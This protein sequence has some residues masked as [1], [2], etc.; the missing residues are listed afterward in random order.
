MTTRAFPTPAAF[1]GDR[2]VR[3]HLVGAGGTGSMLADHLGRL[4][5][6]LREQNHPG[7]AV[8]VYDDALVRTAN[9]GRQRFAAGDVGFHKAIVLV[10]RIND[11]YALDWTTALR[12]YG[13]AEPTPDLLIGCVDLGRFRYDLGMAN[14]NKSTDCLWLDTGNGADRG[15]VLCGHLGRPQRGL[16]LPNVYDLYRD[17]LLS[18]D[19]DDLPSCSLAEALSRQHWSVNPTIAVA[20]AELLDNLF[21]HGGLDAHG[22]YIRLNPMSIQSVPVDPNAW[23]LL[24]YRAPRRRKAA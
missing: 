19:D 4:D 12:R 15:Q 5:R 1:L 2:A 16:R 22:A 8:T 18:G 13:K 6:A 24:G 10:Q 7:L 3:V 9:I 17:E 11:H 20:A 14:A 23:A 21:H